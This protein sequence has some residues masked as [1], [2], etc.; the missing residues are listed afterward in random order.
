VTVKQLVQVPVPAFGLVTVTFLAPVGPPAAIV[1]LTVSWVALL[2]V[3]VLTEMPEPENKTVA[4]LTNPVPVMTTFPVV[5]E[6]LDAGLVEVGIGA[7]ATVNAPVFVRVPPSGFV[8][9]TSLLPV[10]AVA[11]IVMLTVSC[12]ALL[13][14]VELT[15]IPDPENVTVAPLTKF[16][17]VIVIV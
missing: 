8:T 6:P 11:A 14:V 13:N 2:N 7:A 12:V 16:V 5:P 10:V 15:V 4:P 3:V 9:V 17:P 1:M